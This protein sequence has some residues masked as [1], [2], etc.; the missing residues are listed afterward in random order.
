MSDLTD[1]QVAFLNKFLGL[2]IG[3]SEG[4]SDGIDARRHAAMASKVALMVEKH[5]RAG[6]ILDGLLR[7]AGTALAEGD[8]AEFQRQAQLLDD[9]L[10]ALGEMQ[11]LP[12]PKEV[13]DRGLLDLS[14]ELSPEEAAA[15]EIAYNEAQETI[16]ELPETVRE[17]A[18]EYV[19]EMSRMRQRGEQ[20][21]ERLKAGGLSVKERAAHHSEIDQICV[22]VEQLA[23]DLTNILKREGVL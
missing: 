14:R 13:L 18:R 21:V 12:D 2:G 20:L 6:R 8:T 1:Q 19:V 5:P 11:E 23:A 7:A 17:P 3:R 15:L 16:G 9:R 10:D 4:V 22:R